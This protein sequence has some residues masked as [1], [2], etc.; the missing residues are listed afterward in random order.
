LVLFT[1]GCGGGKK[2]PEPIQGPAK[3]V[4][5]VVQRFAQATADGDFETVCTQLLAAAVREQAG[6][7]D[8]PRLMQRRAAG[9]ERPRIQI[10]SI[11]VKSDRARV[12]VRT[13]ALGQAPVDDEIRLVREGGSF[14]ISELGG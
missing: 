2:K 4:A 13:T 6:G 10:A 1:G 7:D 12:R 3:E 14:R 9:V 11:A 5:D 8:C